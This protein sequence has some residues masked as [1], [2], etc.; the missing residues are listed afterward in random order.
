MAYQFT[1]YNIA[2]GF[3]WLIRDEENVLQRQLVYNV[4]QE[5]K[6]FS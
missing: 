1:F 5:L 3:N 2:K 4:E 6:S